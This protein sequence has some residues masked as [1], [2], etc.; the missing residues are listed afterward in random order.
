MIKKKDF[1]K[2]LALNL[3]I[4]VKILNVIGG[5]LFKLETLV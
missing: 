5:R 4:S 2:I 3:E 1:D